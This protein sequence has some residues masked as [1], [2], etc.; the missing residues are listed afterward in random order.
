MIFVEHFYFCGTSEL[1][2][3]RMREMREYYTRY[4]TAYVELDVSGTYHQHF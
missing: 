4:A 1:R 2:A 3:S